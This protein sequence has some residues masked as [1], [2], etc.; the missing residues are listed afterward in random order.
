VQ[1]E[2]AASAT[3]RW[4]G[5]LA[6]PPPLADFG[7]TYSRATGTVSRAEGLA[8]YALGVGLLEL[9]DSYTAAS[10]LAMAR[11]GLGDTAAV[12]EMLAI[13]YDRLNMTR[14][15]L[16]VMPCLD[17]A[18]RAHE[19]AARLY[20]RLEKQL[21]VEQEF[22]AA[23]SDHFVASYPAAGSSAEAIGS[24]L[25]LLERAR[26]QVVDDL[27]IGSIRLVP[28]V[29]YEG[30]QFAAATNKPHWASGLYDGKIRMSIETWRERPQFFETALTHEY[31]HALTHE[32]TGTRLPSW[33][34]EGIADA[35]ARNGS[36]PARNF[37]PGDTANRI[38]EIDELNASFME[39]PEDLARAAYLQSH[40]MVLGLVLESGWGAI[41]ALI[42]DLHGDRALE[43]DTAFDDFF[44]ETPADYL[45][46]WYSN[47]R[48]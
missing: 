39:L 4:A 36:E 42:L 17:A 45:D 15:L 47:A 1:R 35:L 19:S 25:D 31:V 14:D 23:A 32:Y 10:H 13:A 46:R 12:C 21:D 29:V 28:V 40:A 2:P 18:A 37:T 33:F 16:G 7:G 43:F 8:H 20:D 38:L 5:D 11:D 34:R 26:R 24:V 30:D 9:G 6:T 22:L 48:R 41:E 27:G 3:V 44:G